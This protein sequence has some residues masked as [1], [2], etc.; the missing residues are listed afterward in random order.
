MIL[1]AGTIFTVDSPHSPKK[2]AGKKIA[3]NS[4]MNTE[5]KMAVNLEESNFLDVD[6]SEV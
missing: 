1:E 6:R 2:F 4:V 3:Q 5:K